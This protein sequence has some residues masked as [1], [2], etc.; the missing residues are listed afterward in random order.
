MTLTL[1]FEA[2]FRHLGGQLV[3]F[4]T[5]ELHMG[6]NERTQNKPGKLR[7]LLSTYEQTITYSGA[8]GPVRLKLEKMSR[9]SSSR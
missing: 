1:Y 6:E 9:A 2:L 7:S 3:L 5:Y 8:C 4:S